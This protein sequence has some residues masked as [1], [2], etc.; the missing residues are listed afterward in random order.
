MKALATPL[1]GFVLAAAGVLMAL[2]WYNGQPWWLYI[3]GAAAV[4][5]F[6][7]MTVVA[8]RLLP[9]NPLAALA[10]FEWRLLAV[11]AITAVVGAIAIIIG[12]EWVIPDPKPE[13]PDA[14]F[15]KAMKAVVAAGVSALLAFITAFGTKAEGFDESVGDVVSSAF[16]KKYEEVPR[17]A[18]VQIVKRG[19]RT[20]ITLPR[21]SQG[22][23]VVFSAYALEGWSK[24]VRRQRATRL[25]AYLASHAP[26]PQGE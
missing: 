3:I 5:S 16:S 1:L 24:A 22:W 19:R 2:G 17:D 25:N 4:A 11:A 20:V 9:R 10:W 6:V 26:I 8:W 21:E 13:A 12:I 14:D 7:V 15:Q 18:A 23:E